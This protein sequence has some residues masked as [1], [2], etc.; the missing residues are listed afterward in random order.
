M[1]RNFNN[2]GTIL[3]IALWIMA[4]LML[5]A[6]S[7][8]YRSRVEIKLSSLSSKKIK[9][10]EMAW[11]G[12]FEISRLLKDDTNGYDSLNEEWALE[13]GDE[14]ISYAIIDE[15]R[16]INLNIASL[17]LLKAIPGMDED[18]ASG[19]IDWRDLDND[20]IAE[21]MYYMGLEPAYHC[22][23]SQLESMEELLAIKGITPEILETLKTFSTI[24]GHGKVNIN[25]AS[26]EAL[27]ALLSS[28]TPPGSASL[29]DKILLYRD[30]NIFNEI[31]KVKEDLNNTIGL[32]PEEEN[33]ID[34]MINLIDVKS[35]CFRINLK[36][37]YENKYSFNVESLLLNSGDNKIKLIYWQEK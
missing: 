25:T 36:A 26:G 12:I 24:Y 22:K 34:R 9:A 4:I 3:I 19:I 15:E 27:G 10:Q 37:R 23:N 30:N 13:R 14:A 29:T 17:D 32:T 20:G 31:S 18:I 1:A 5:V 11:E 21:D 33:S 6:V 16:K 7:L 8:A 28:L 2:S 35:T